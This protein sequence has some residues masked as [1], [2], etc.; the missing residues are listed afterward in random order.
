VYTDKD[1]SGHFLNLPGNH[2]L[3]KMKDQM[4]KGEQ[5][6]EGHNSLLLDVWSH[7]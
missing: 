2:C 4:K 7:I 1:Y 6:Y 5:E 3:I